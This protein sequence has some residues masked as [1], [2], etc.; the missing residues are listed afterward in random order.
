MTRLSTAWTPS[1]TPAG[2]TPADPPVD[3]DPAG[4]LEECRRATLAVDQRHQF[5]PF[6]QRA[7]QGRGQDAMRVAGSRP[8]TSYLAESAMTV[9]PTP[10]NSACLSPRASRWPWPRHPV[11]RPGPRRVRPSTP[12]LSTI[13]KCRV[14]DLIAGEPGPGDPS[15]I[16]L[17]SPNCM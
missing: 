10:S 4:G 6:E 8:R 2:S 3:Q 9:R 14:E 13:C 15:G 5:R 1:A 11:F 17:T 16:C 7:P 12:S